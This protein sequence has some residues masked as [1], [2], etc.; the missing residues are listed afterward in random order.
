MKNSAI[1]KAPFGRTPEGE[2]VEIYTL[3]NDNGLEARIMTY[4]GIVVSLKTPDKSGQFDDVVLGYD[5][6]EGYL[7]RNP[8]FGALIGRCGNRIS[9]GKF[10]LNGSTYSLAQNIGSK[11]H[12]HGG[13]KGF[14][15]VVWTAKVVE[16]SNGPALQLDYLSKDGE[17]GYPGNLSVTAIHTLTADNGLRIDF[18]ATTDKH[19]ICNLTHH[20]YFNFHGGGDVLDYLV[21][22]NAEHFTAVNEDVIPTGELRP[23]DGTP[24]DFRK[25]TR[26]GA[27]IESLDEQIQLAGGYDHNWVFNKPAG[28]LAAVARVADKTSGRCME[29]FT[30]QPG[31]QFY[32]GNFL[33]GTITGKGGQ[34]YHRR[35]A[36]CMEPQH[37]PDAPNHPK[38]PS[39]E[40]KPGQ[41]YK[42]TIVYKFSTE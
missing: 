19:T 18:N 5:S 30:T 12:L 34:K 2:P 32:S 6:L 21:Q 8:Y 14:D 4:G 3:R 17:E 25:P 11:N 27:R 38:F 16:T 40:L 35:Y 42:N 9:K 29:V 31:M 41:V 28:H 37:Y 20:S 7:K 1:S 23:V 22:I 36:F 26:I 39:I 10:S 13:L 33:D 24:L 15:K